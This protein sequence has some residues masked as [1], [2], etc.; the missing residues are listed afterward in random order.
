MCYLWLCKSVLPVW[1]GALFS[2]AARDDH[3]R[4]IVLTDYVPSNYPRPLSFSSMPHYV[5]IRLTRFS[6]R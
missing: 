4:Q 3:H 5:N 1:A 6:L 2:I